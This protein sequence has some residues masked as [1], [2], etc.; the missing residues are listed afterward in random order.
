MATMMLPGSGGLRL[1]ADV[2]GD[3]AAPGVLLLHGG[4]QT[5]HSWKST[6]AHLAGLGYFVGSV[7]LRGHGESDWSTTGDYSVDDYASDVR[8]LV[9]WMHRP[10]ALVGASLG[11]ISSLLAIAE[12]PT[13]ACAALVLVDIVP[14]MSEAGKD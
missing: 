9:R 14:G 7:D 11:G 3:E 6:A 10:T 2:L 1:R 8:S 4:G 5:R 12:P 13:V